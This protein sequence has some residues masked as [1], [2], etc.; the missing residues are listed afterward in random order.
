MVY[1]KFGK[2]DLQV[3]EIGFGAWAIGG[4]SWGDTGDDE[5][6]KKALEQAW[7]SGINLYDTCDAYGDGHSEILI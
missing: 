2:T 7:E 1:R 5:E 3:S 6:A 4:K